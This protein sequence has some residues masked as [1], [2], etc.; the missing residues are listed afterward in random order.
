MKRNYAALSKVLFMIMMHS[1]MKEE[2]SWDSEI[3]IYYPI[4]F[5]N[6]T[7]T[8]THSN[9][10]LRERTYE[11]ITNKVRQTFLVNVDNILIPL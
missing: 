2:E 11:R 8:K 4:L 6:F 7:G 10:C 5:P 3:S 9:G 1:S